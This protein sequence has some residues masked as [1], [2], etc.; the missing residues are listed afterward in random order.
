M[1]PEKHDSVFTTVSNCYK[2]SPDSLA[3]HLKNLVHLVLLHGYVPLNLVVCTLFPLIK[4]TFG[5]ITSS[6]N[7]RAIGGG[8]LLLKIIDLVFLSLEG[9]TLGVS[10]LQFAYQ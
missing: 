2:E 1:K 6:E 7:Y 3:F 4:D 9:H 10:E 5:N 8:C